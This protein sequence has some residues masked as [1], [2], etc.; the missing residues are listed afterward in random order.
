MARFMSDEYLAEVARGNVHG[1]RIINKFG[2]NALVDSTLKPITSTGFFRTPSTLTSLEIVSSSLDDNISGTGAR[3]VT[4]YGLTT[5]WEEVNE[6]VEMNG[7]TAVALANQ[8]YRVYRVRVATSGSYATQ[9][10]AS[11][12]GTIT[13]RESGAGQTWAEIPLEGVFGFGSSEIG[14]ATIPAGHTGYFLG[15]QIF[16]ETNKPCEVI[17]FIRKQANIVTAPYSPVTGISIQRG[18]LNG[19]KSGPRGFGDPMVGPTDIGFMASNPT[20]TANISVEFQ[21]L[22]LKDR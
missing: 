21:L 20:G 8:Y 15:K 4:V 6:V 11:H 22:L 19:Y 9:I 13:V 1:A 5:D 18:V 16:I 2:H 17:M 3:T 7:T 12:I 14:V 10:Q